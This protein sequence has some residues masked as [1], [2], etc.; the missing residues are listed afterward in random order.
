MFLPI[1]NNIEKPGIIVGTRNWN[2]LNLRKAVKSVSDRIAN[3]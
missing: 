1:F 2:K 3:K